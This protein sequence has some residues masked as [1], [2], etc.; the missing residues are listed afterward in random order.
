MQLAVRRVWCT[1]QSTISS[2]YVD[3]IFECYGLEPPKGALRIPAGTYEVIIGWS[4]KFERLMPRL[5]AV[6]GWP[7]DDV[8]IHWGNYPSNTEG[9]L[10]VGETRDV[11]F[12]GASRA[13]F[14]TLYAKLPERFQITYTDEC[15]EISASV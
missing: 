15:D 8:E 1:S 3:G 12:V 4:P 14:D 5:Q 11:D 10:L 2:V 7:N 13:A 9:C 6:P